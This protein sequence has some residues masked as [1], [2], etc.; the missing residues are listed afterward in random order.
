MSSPV[1][2]LTMAPLRSRTEHTWVSHEGPN[3]AP[4]KTQNPKMGKFLTSPV[5]IK[6][7]GQVATAT[8]EPEHKLEIF[9]G[10]IDMIR[11]DL[12]RVHPSVCK[13]SCKYS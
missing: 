12:L 1:Q 6:A 7:F 8:A 13:S 3:M 10:E 11:R 5:I 2:K 4:G 9:C